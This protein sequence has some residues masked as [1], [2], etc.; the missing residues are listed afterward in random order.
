MISIGLRQEWGSGQ[1]TNT[2]SDTLVY[3]PCVLWKEQRTAV[4]GGSIERNDLQLDWT[5]PG[6]L[7][8]GCSIFRKE[9]TRSIWE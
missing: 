8:S 7:C 3:A 2:D 9:S 6:A 1:G 5:A 4:G